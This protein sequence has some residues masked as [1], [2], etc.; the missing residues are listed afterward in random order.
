MGTL[1][2]RI[3]YYLVKLLEGQQGSLRI[4]R[5]EVAE[6]FGCAPSQISYV[7]QTRFTPARGY[8]VASQRG[9]GGYIEIYKIRV[10]S[11][12][13]LLSTI[14]EELEDEIDPQQGLDILKRLKAEGLL[15]KREALLL[16]NIMRRETLSD[17]SPYH[18]FIRGRILKSLVE[19]LYWTLRKEE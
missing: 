2:A 18:D 10:E 13:D 15:S 1:A 12:V 14:Y 17:F 5:G 7:L 16:G 4:Q 11:Y 9:G 8:I 6:Y 3:E 19:S